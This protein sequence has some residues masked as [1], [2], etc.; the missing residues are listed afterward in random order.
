MLFRS[1]LFY[2]GQMAACKPSCTTILYRHTIGAA[3]YRSSQH[4][5]SNSLFLS[6]GCAYLVRSSLSVVSFANLT[7][8][9]LFFSSITLQYARNIYQAG[10]SCSGRRSIERAGGGCEGGWQGP[11]DVL[12]VEF[13]TSGVFSGD[14]QVDNCGRIFWLA[15]GC[16][17]WV[18]ALNS[19]N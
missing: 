15:W 10:R 17:S 3:I 2:D 14:V 11:I 6:L 19:V 4:D 5:N 12:A 18:L 7:P 8:N 16:G 9:F 13:S 1:H